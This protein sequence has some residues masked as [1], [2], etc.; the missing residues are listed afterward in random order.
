MDSGIP[1][2]PD[3]PQMRTLEVEHDG[4]R[5]IIRPQRTFGINPE[6]DGDWSAPPD[7]RLR[8]PVYGNRV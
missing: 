1:S 4:G 6:V 7:Q 8:R 5:L 2:K 3:T